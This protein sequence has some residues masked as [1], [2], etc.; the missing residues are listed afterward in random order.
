VVSALRC[1]EAITGLPA[2]E[3]LAAPEIARVL[4]KRRVVESRMRSLRSVEC[5]LRQSPKEALSE[6]FKKLRRTASTSSS[7]RLSSRFARTPQTSE[8]LAGNESTSWR[9]IGDVAHDVL[10]AAITAR[11]QL[12]Q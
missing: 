6:T 12:R 4:S 11:M 10:R 8:A 9:P 5:E 7:K 2:I 1:T 3:T